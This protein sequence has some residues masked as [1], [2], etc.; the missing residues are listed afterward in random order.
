MW[1]D[2]PASISHGLTFLTVLVAL[3]LIF[4]GMMASNGRVNVPTNMPQAVFRIRP[5]IRAGKIF[6]ISREEQTKLN[7][8]TYF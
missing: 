3:T 5:I 2:M 1:M 8:T 7:S 6:M 4:V